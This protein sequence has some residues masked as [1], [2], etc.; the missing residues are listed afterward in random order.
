VPGVVLPGV[1]GSVLPGVVGAIPEPAAPE[2]LV[3]APVL[4]PLGGVVVVVPALGG[5][6]VPD[7]PV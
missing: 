1:P 3:P 2:P 4:V 6:L 7:E 5:V